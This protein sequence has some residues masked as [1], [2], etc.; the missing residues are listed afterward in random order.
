MCG[1][2]LVPL[3]T[4]NTSASCCWIQF[5]LLRYVT[6]MLFNNK[7][8]IH[9]FICLSV[10]S[11]MYC[12]LKLGILISQ[13]ARA[14]LL[15]LLVMFFY[16]KQPHM[17]VK[18][19][20]VNQQFKDFAVDF[21]V[22]NFQQCIKFCNV[23]LLFQKVESSGFSSVRIFYKRSGANFPTLSCVKP[24]IKNLSTFFIQTI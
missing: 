11:S 7:N 4:V 10:C 6:N 2:L 8:S 17:H 1:C 21:A 24:N 19:C 5:K 13:L 15:R 20:N 16:K 22:V 14:E 9:N 23:P 3:P 18:K 12:S